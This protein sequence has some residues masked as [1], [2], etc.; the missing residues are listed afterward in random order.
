LLCA[1]GGAAAGSADD[2]Q[3]SGTLYLWGA[4]IKGETAGGADFDID[5][6]TLIDNLNMTLMGALEA[7]RREWSF[8]VDGIYL[9]VGGDDSGTV[10]VTTADGSNLLVDVDADLKLRAWIFNLHGAYSLL[11]T[12]QGSL[13]VLAGARYLEVKTEFDLGLAAGPARVDRSLAV[14]GTAW[15]GVVGVKGRVNLAD[16]WYLPY[17]VDVGTGDSDL[18]WQIFGGVAYSFDWGEVSL[19]YRYLDWDFDSDSK[20]DN[21]TVQGP[22]A[23]IT[24]HF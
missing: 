3:Y 15:D 14:L 13:D 7:R 9:N 12:E 16:R 23:A 24:L 11:A 10:P 18:T 21:L 6:S 4:S 19:V 17:Y 22:A 20:L 8:V 1:S 2:W 5:F